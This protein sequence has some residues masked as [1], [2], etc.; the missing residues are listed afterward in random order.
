MKAFT[1][2]QPWATL[3]AISA[4]RIETRSWGTDYRG[5]L[6]IHAAKGW[7]EPCV[8]LFFKEPFKSILEKAGYKLFSLLPRGEVIAVCDLVSVR[9]ITP[10][11]FRRELPGWSWTG[12][13]GAEYRFD[14]DD[15]EFVV[16]FETDSPND[17]LDLIMKLRETES[18][19]FTL[20]DTPIFTCLQMPLADCL[21]AL[22]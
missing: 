8:R 4:K 9:E 11:H 15:Q 10:A 20:R 17:F 22:G 13:D 6:A 3:V 12:P 16:A 21:S 19:L 1:L 7:T 2:T 14:L 18:S 5:P